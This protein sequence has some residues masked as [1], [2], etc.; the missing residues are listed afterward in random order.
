[1]LKEVVGLK[2]PTNQPKAPEVK[3]TP[4]PTPQEEAGRARNIVA[5]E[6]VAKVQGTMW[7]K[8]GP[9]APKGTPKGQAEAM[10]PASGWGQV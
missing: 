1:M 10:K 6:I 4:A 7:Q 5:P 8:P 3:S 9:G 2:S